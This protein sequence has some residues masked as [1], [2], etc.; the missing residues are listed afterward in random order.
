M[1][2]LHAAIFHYF[3]MRLKLAAASTLANAG[4]YLGEKGRLSAPSQGTWGGMFYA[5]K[6]Y[7]FHYAKYG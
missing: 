6:I 3:R 2:I 7:N 4:A 1:T 5:S